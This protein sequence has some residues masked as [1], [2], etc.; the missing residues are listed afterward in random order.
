MD[1]IYSFD[2]E[3]FYL[4]TLCKHGHNWPGTNQ[5]LR[6]IYVSPQGVKINPCAG[7]KGRK[8]SS[9]LISFIDSAAMGLPD[10]WRMGKLCKGR[11][12]WRGHKMTLYTQ[13][14]KCPDCERNRRK[15][16]RYRSSTAKWRAENADLLKQQERAAYEKRKKRAAEDPEYAAGLQMRQAQAMRL[17]R[18]KNGRPSRAK[19]AEGKVLPVGVGRGAAVSVLLRRG[20]NAEFLAMAAQEHKALWAAIRQ[21][22][23]LPSVVQLVLQ[24]Q[25]RYWQ[26]N[27]DDYLQFQREK[28][29]QYD[30][31]KRISDP[32]YRLY[33]RQKSRRRKALERG[34]IGIQFKGKQIAKRFEEFGNRCAYCG[35]K[36]ATGRW[37]GLQA[38]HVIPISKGGTHVLSNVVPACRACNFSK[39]D[40]DAE[41]WYRAQPFFCEKRWRKI[42][43]VL[44][45]RKGPATQLALL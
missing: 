18:Q 21:A 25:R 26:E 17:C 22:G 12:R 43:R 37:Q 5:S 24:E 11:H 38:D 33:H 7:C 28:Q 13:F 4:G 19:G 20:V 39:R 36:G 9:W 30:Q 8:N 10:G 34:S 2:P 23:K 27:P 42:L 29:R 16:E 31:W 14:N 3:R 40:K 15:T 35:G 44:G 32:A 6:Q 1:L 45:V 41:A